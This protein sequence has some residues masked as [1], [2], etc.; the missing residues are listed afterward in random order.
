MFLTLPE[1]N[2]HKTT[3]ISDAI[4]LLNRELFYLV[5]K[6]VRECRVIHGIG[7]GKLTDAIHQE[8]NKNPIV[9]SFIEESSG[10]SCFVSL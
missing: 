6:G 5:Q 1:I 2:L 7:T 8:L 4:F 9:S 3:I 10:G